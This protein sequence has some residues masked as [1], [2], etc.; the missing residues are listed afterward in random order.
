MKGPIMELTMDQ[1]KEVV[2]AS[3]SASMNDFKKELSDSQEAVK[4]VVKDIV[5]TQEQAKAGMTADKVL[6]GVERELAFFKALAFGD[7]DKAKAMG[8][9]EGSEGGF[10]VP[11]E[12]EARVMMKRENVNDLRKYCTVLPTTSGTGEMPSE[13]TGVLVERPGENTAPAGQDP[14][15]A[16]VTYSVSTAIAYFEMSQQLLKDAGVPMLDYVATLFSKGFRKDDETMIIGGSGTAQPEGIRSAGIT[17]IAMAGASLAWDDVT[18]LYYSLERDRRAEGI[19]LGSNKALRLLAGLKDTAD[20]P[21]LF[22]P[23]EEGGVSKMLGRPVIE[24]TVIPENLGTG[25]DET[26]LWFVDLSA[27]MIADRQGM[28]VESSTQAGDTFKKHQMAL[29]AVKRWDGKLAQVE[30]AQFLTAVK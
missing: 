6:K 11:T 23:K 8:E 1:L 17:G 16:Q 7:T 18:N 4:T 27:Y 15:L 22:L 12:F 19:W 24:S 29:K 13:G 9:G 20:A 30:G 10:L 2:G 26:E 25:T 14:S 21:V 28:E 5:P 3:V